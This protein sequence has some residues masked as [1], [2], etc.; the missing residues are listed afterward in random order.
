[1]KA[2]RIQELTTKADR[3]QAAVE[4]LDQEI[5]NAIADGVDEEVIADMRLRRRELIEQTDDVG[6]ALVIL[7]KRA[8]DP[9]HK[10]QAAIIAGGLRDAK[11]EAETY[12]QSAAAVDAALASVEKSLTDLQRHGND[13]QK[14]LRIAG[15]SDNARIS[16]TLQ[17]STRWA[18]WKSAPILAELANVPFTP[19]NKRY[20]LAHSARRVI[21]AIGE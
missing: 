12:I 20:T 2:D 17:S 19:G 18:M 3:A 6:E 16:N 4:A 1:M 8:N 15:I 9:R 13:L 10:L 7:E 21:P 11:R 14:A 5:A